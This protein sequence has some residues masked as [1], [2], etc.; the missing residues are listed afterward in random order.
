MNDYK[1]VGA[2]LFLSLV[3]S[4]CAAQVQVENAWIQLALSPNTDHA[5]YMTIN[6]PQLRSQTVVGVSA[7]CCNDAIIQKRRREGDK[8]VLDRL[9]YLVIPS[10]GMLQLAPN[11]LQLTLLEPK[12]ELTDASRVK[13]TFSFSDGSTQ[14]IELGVKPS[15]Q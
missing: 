14:E 11:E 5:A 1:K 9:D 7:D 12:E 8:V 4:H 6:N 3:A 2:S 10:Q 13:V 15:Q